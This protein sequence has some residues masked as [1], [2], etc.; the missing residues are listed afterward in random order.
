MSTYSQKVGSWIK[1]R[2]GSNLQDFC[3]RF[4]YYPVAVKIMGLDENDE[5]GTK[6]AISRD[7]E[8]K[9]LYIA[10]SK[11][12]KAISRKGD[13]RSWTQ[14]FKDLIT[15][16]I[17]EDLTM[18][19]FKRQGIDIRHNGKDSKRVIEVDGNVSQDADFIV[20][21][22]DV[23]RRVELTNEFNSI[24]YEQGFIEKRAPALFNL[25]KNKGIWVFRDIDRGKYV[26]V[27]FGTENIVLHLRHHNNTA[28][29][30]SKDVHRYVLSENGKKVRD[31][32]MLAAEIISVVGCSVEGRDRP[33]L[34]EIEDKDSPPQ[35]FT[36][37]GRFR[38]KEQQLPLQ[39][40]VQHR[41]EKEKTIVEKSPTKPPSKREEPKKP[42]VETPSIVESSSETETED[43]MDIDNGIEMDLGDGDFV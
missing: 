1:E 21:V 19:Q 24:L 14:Y 20:T 43:E 40:E 5:K 37:E 41:V 4:G 30:W 17:L 34:T 27:D 11:S 15:G 26:L 25:W 22:G 36:I 3:K 8:L 9:E 2:S 32:R 7:K 18:E 12:P 23:S 31:E 16:W 29:D 35:V 13:N 39:Q 10:C 6:I 42:E 33:A 28:K 38:G